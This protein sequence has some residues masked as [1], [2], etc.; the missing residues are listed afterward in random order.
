M[1][2]PPEITQPKVKD[3]F[4]RKRPCKRWVLYFSLRSWPYTISGRF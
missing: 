1:I 4:T 2:Q 3:F